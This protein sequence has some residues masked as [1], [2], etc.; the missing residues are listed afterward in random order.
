MKLDYAGNLKFTF[1]YKM[2]EKLFQ[3]EST[4]SN[5]TMSTC[6]Y[7]VKVDGIKAVISGTYCGWFQNLKAADKVTYM[8]M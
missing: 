2:E 7:S 5:Q 1:Q 8:R 6:L 4:N 3:R